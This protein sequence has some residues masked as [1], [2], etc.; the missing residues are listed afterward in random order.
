MAKPT[1]VEALISRREQRTRLHYSR[2][3]TTKLTPAQRRAFSPREPRGTALLYTRVLGKLL[4]GMREDVDRI[5]LPVLK[6]A[7]P[8]LQGQGVT[9]QEDARVWRVGVRG[10][11]LPCGC[12]NTPEWY[13]RVLRMDAKGRNFNVPKPASMYTATLGD[14][15]VA[16]TRRTQA[17]NTRSS[18]IEVATSLY[19]H[20]RREMERVLQIDLRAQNQ[21][22][23]PFIDGFLAKNTS[24][25]KSISFDVM[26]RLTS[27]VAEST[28]GQFRV[29]V[30]AEEI[31]RSFDVSESRAALIARD[32]TLKANSDLIQLRQQQVGVTEYIWTSS[33]DERVRGRPGGKWEKSKANHWVLDGTR[34]LWLVAPVTNPDTG[35]TNHPGQ[36]YQC[37]C[38]ATPVI[39]RLLE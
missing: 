32:Q 31:A 18:L 36:D 1:L 17:Q 15:E 8:E 34:Q 20:N 10:D 16:V 29:E 9:S 2:R 11:T 30:L 27:V 19:K 13:L 6:A 7:A 37:R 14:L 28:A 21:G 33:R 4:A 3:S 22:L 23:G 39:D 38:T 5:L 35:D 26:D 24:L 12:G 25:I